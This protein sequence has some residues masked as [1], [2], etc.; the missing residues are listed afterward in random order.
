MDFEGSLV[1]AFLSS[2]PYG[3]GSWAV[4]MPEL[5]ISLQSHAVRSRSTASRVLI[6]F[7]AAVRTGG[8]PTT[9]VLKRDFIKVPKFLTCP[10]QRGY[11]V[12]A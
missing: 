9:G 7:C 12:H 3:R 5:S 6:N 8:E 11:K 1:F 10:A 2:M 4:A